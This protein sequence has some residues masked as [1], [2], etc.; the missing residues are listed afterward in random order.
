MREALAAGEGY[1]LA[2]TLKPDDDLIGI[3]GLHPHKEPQHRKAELG[4]WLGIPYWNGGYITEAAR[5]MLEL[6]F[7]SLGLNRI[8]A[9]HFID[10]PASGRVMQK[11]GMTY[12]GTLRQHWYRG[13]HYRDTAYY[14]ILREDYEQLA[15]S[16]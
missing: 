16:E 2:I 14:G 3:I 9:S 13:D 15:R 1:V 4:Y 7:R 11:L 10:N 12:E 8:Y 6:G 5:C